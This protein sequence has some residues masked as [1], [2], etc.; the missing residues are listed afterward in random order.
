MAETPHTESNLEP[1]IV[2]LETSMQHIRSDIAD[3]KQDIRELRRDT[4]AGFNAIEGRSQAIEGRAWSNFIIG[5]AGI[6]GAFIITWGGILWL[7]LKLNHLEVLLTKLA[8]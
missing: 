3:I 8:H 2:A 5:W 6:I 1:R 7:G 4:L